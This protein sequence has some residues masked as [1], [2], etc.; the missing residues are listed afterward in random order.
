MLKSILNVDC[1]K[2]LCLNYLQKAGLKYFAPPV[3]Y[4]SKKNNKHF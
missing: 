1:N 2:I 3:D 4:R